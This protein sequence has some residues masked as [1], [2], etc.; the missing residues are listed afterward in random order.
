LKDYTDDEFSLYGDGEK[1]VGKWFERTGKR[2]EIFLAT[3]FGFV[4][5]SKSYEVDSSREYCKKACD[6][7]LKALGVD[8][9]DLC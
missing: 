3:K 4:K 2:N 8:S 1:L 7:S 6:E 5:G 9:I